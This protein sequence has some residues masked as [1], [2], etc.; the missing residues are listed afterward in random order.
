VRGDAAA[1]MR[2]F[3]GAEDVLERAEL[4]LTRAALRHVHGRFLGGDA[5]RALVEEAEAYMRGEG[6]VAPARV[7]RMFAPGKE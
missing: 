7:V 1:A 4:V 3:A 5:G 6:I 2:Y